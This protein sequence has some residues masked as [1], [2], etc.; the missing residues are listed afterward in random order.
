MNIAKLNLDPLPLLSLNMEV[1]ACR[2]P[3]IEKSEKIFDSKKKVRKK[4]GVVMGKKKKKLKV[5]AKANI[6]I[7]KSGKL[8]INGG[9]KLDLNPFVNDSVDNTIVSRLD[10]IISKEK[11]ELEDTVT[12]L[13]ISCNL[14]DELRTAELLSR[15][16]NLEVPTII[17]PVQKKNALDCFDYLEDNTLGKILRSST[18]AAVYMRVKNEWVD[19]CKEDKTGFTN[20]LYV[21]NV[22]VFI[23]AHG[24]LKKKPF[25][26][27]VCVVAIPSPSKMELSV[28]STEV[29]EKPSDEDISAR[30]IADMIE[31]TIKCGG[32]RVIVNPFAAKALT[33]DVTTTSDLWDQ[34]LTSERSIT[35]LDCVDFALE[36]EDKF[37]VFNAR[38]R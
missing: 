23:N 11:V 13:P 30:I 33:K 28:D 34:I 15:S 38:R 3:K 17:I 27:N 20:V 21:P 25:K 29:V 16:N 36:D 32:R 5:S 22:L 24:E 9:Q 26:I 19:L 2:L 14:T 7:L 35:Q 37:V 10:A 31:A 18:L 6:Q 4:E 8:K 1:S 12:K